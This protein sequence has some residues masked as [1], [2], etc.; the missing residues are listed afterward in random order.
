MNNN[1]KCFEDDR[2]RQKRGKAKDD[3]GRIKITP[4]Y[5]AMAMW[6]PDQ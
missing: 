6:L 4:E 2:R 3:Y 5:L 1:E